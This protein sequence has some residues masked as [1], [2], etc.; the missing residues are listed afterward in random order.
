M[1]FLWE[2]EESIKGDDSSSSSC[3]QITESALLKE[4]AEMEPNTEDSAR[5]VCTC[6]H[7]QRRQHG[8]SKPH[9]MASSSSLLWPAYGGESAIRS[10]QQTLLLAKASQKLTSTWNPN[11]GSQEHSSRTKRTLWSHLCGRSSSIL[12]DHHVLEQMVMRMLF[13][14][15]SKLTVCRGDGDVEV[16]NWAGKPKLEIFWK[17]DIL[18][19]V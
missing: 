19:G 1:Q 16:G 4:Q 3:A 12:L 11:W 2:R 17:Y 9:S 10:F 15:R 8:L 14:Q 6:L 13:L 5:Y 7:G 18:P